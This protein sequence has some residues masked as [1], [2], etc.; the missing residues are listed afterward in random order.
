MIGLIGTPGRMTGS[1][2]RGGGWA[3][4]VALLLGGV[5]GLS[6]PLPPTSADGAAV[7]TAGE[8]PWGQA[9][10]PDPQAQTQRALAAAIVSPS[11]WKPSSSWPGP[12]SVRLADDPSRQ[13][14]SRATAV[15]R[16]LPGA[17]PAV[18]P[19]RQAY[20][21]HAPPFVAS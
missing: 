11:R 4:L 10:L 7:L 17:S 8:A 1:T 3:I 5:L 20:D 18:R 2:A 6:M 13:P 19:L 15:R 14:A 12:E 21:P 9:K 16:Q